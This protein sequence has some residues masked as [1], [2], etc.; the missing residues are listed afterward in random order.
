MAEIVKA[1]IYQQLNSALRELIVTGE[2]QA[3]AKFLSER[4]ISERFEVSRAT[5]NKALSTLV[6][7]G[8]LEFRKGVGTFVAERAMAYDL[9]QLVS[10]TAKAESAGFRPATRVIRFEKKRGRDL[11][12]EALA[13]LDTAPNDALFHVERLRLADDSPVILERRVIPAARCPDLTA[14]ELKG[15]IYALFTERYGLTI[16]G[17]E[18][19]ISA[20]TIDHDDAALLEV[21][22]GS[23]C[24]LA[25]SSGYTDDALPLWF[26]R[27]LYRGDV[28]T[29]RNRMT[30]PGM[31]QSPPAS[32][33]FERR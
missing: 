25:V 32:L 9:R 28:Y 1:P 26:E 22:P 8:I 2:F 15:S 21:P 17:A 29:F 11:D 13:L 12:A 14:Q 27:T 33:L 30:G 6:A 31:T 18:Q 3:G 20:V 7:E 4:E 23:A 19:R 5:T 24:L 16:A 10:F